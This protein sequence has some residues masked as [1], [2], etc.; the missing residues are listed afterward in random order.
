VSWD[1]RIEPTAAQDLHDLGPSAAI[2]FRDCLDRRIRGT[3]DPRLFGKLLRGNLSGFWRYRVRDSRL[4]CRLED[5]VLIVA[6]GH[7]SKIYED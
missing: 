3:A 4:L 2:E 7:R 1:Y 5:T 6:V